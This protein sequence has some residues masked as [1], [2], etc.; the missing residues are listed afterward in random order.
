[1]NAKVD[2]SRVKINNHIWKVNVTILNYRTVCLVHLD[3]MGFSR[4]AHMRISKDWE[5]AL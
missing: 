2:V 3:I 5:H 4:S 1:M